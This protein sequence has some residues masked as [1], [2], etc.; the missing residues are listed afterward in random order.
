MK[1]GRET[2]LEVKLDWTRMQRVHPSTEAAKSSKC[3][4]V[5]TDSVQKILS[6]DLNQEH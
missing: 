5:V 1:S 6:H 3:V 2:I 4:I